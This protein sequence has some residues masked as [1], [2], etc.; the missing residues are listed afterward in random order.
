[1]MKHPL[2][3]MFGLVLMI[4]GFFA[5]GLRADHTVNVWGDRPEW[6]IYWTMAT[7]IAGDAGEYEPFGRGHSHPN[8]PPDEDWMTP[9]FN[10][11]GWGFARDFAPGFGS[12]R[13]W[14]VSG[15]YL[16]RWFEVTDA[17]QVRDLKLDVEY[18][19]GAVVYLNGRELARSHL[20][21]EKLT[22]QTLAEPYP[23]E[24]FF[25]PD[26]EGRLPT[27]VPADPSPELLERYQSRIRTMSVRIPAESLREGNNLVAVAIYRSPYQVRALQGHWSGSHHSLWSTTGLNRA[28]LLAGS[29]SGL[30]TAAD[31]QS[32]RLWNASPMTVVGRY[33]DQGD[34]FAPLSPVSISLPRNG[35]GSGQ[36]VV[37]GVRDG[38]KLKAQVSELVSDQGARL[39]A[40]DVRIRYGVTD[41]HDAA[42]PFDVL[43]PVAPRG[44]STI[45]V[46]LTVSASA[47]AEPGTYRGTLRVAV[48][49]VELEAPVEVRVAA[50]RVAQP[51]DFTTWSG[52]FQSTHS[53]A[54]RYGVAM[55]SD[56]H[57]ALI[58]QSLKYLGK[59]GNQIA[60]IPAQRDMSMLR[61]DPM[62]LFRRDAQG[63]MVPDLRLVERYLR[64]YDRHVGEP[65]VLILH[66]WTAN[67]DPRQDR[68]LT[69]PVSE[70]RG[71]RIVDAEI[72]NFGEPGSEAIWARV[73]EAMKALVAELDWDP[74]CLMLGTPSDARPSEQTMATLDRAA[75]D[76]R[77]VAYSHHLGPRPRGLIVF[78]ARHGRG[79][80]GWLVEDP[81]RMT[82]HRGILH[83]DSS[84]PRYRIAAIHALKDG[85]NGVSGKGIDFI[86]I[87][88]DDGETF[89]RFVD[90]R[91]WMR[92]VRGATRAMLAAGPE[93]LLATTRFEMYRQGLQE[94]EAFILIETHKED[95]RLSDE[96]A[97]RAQAIR[98]LIEGQL[99]A[100]TA[101]IAL[102]FTPDG[103]W[104]RIQ[105]ELFECAYQI[106]RA[107]AAP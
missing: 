92:V 75:R 58:E 20:P 61:G 32:P 52:L 72:P 69:I 73:V 95:Q 27:H 74:S 78:P 79:G 31:I 28:D 94:A 76:V 23:D 53:L 40:S 9:G 16:R 106:T 19:G 34:P 2:I 65:R 77:W 11:R 82:N 24:A 43:S 64:L 68:P 10:D 42:I 59:L 36:I 15:I 25:A 81:Y 98:P 44:Q 63:D 107:I 100:Y 48:M 29:A 99:A 3:F 45:P 6:R 37:A 38:A 103:D 60:A 56:E 49:D 26:G 101:F 33:A 50:W 66:L 102:G 14:R 80:Q 21:E 89:E 4:G 12:D 86:R 30:K 85:F 88:R 47:Q 97:A 104:E 8:R 90:M 55:W 84:L 96:L 93:G 57:F 83:H 7:A 105:N 22:P 39:G 46:W 54:E 41:S 87:P 18:R 51:R 91:E 70:L 67:N 35:V 62:L 13:Q 1:M 5:Q 17:R 71:D